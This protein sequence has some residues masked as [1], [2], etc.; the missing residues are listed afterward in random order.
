MDT[1][2]MIYSAILIRQTF[3]TIIFLVFNHYDIHF[4]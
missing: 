3:F 2:I 4:I 1:V